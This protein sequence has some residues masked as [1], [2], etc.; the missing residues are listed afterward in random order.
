MT[1]R[2]DEMPAKPPTPTVGN[3]MYANKN[4]VPGPP[5]TIMGCRSEKGASGRSIAVVQTNHTTAFTYAATRKR[6]YHN[7]F[8]TPKER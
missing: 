1:K 3:K 4:H 6:L 5:P 2:R 8:P 7:A